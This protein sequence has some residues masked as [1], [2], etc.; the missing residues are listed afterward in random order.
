MKSKIIP[1]IIA[2]V[3]AMFFVIMLLA[4]LFAPELKYTTDNTVE[5]NATIVRVV[6]TKNQDKV[7]YVVYTDEYGDKLYIENATTLI[8]HAY[9]NTLGNGQKVSVL[10]PDSLFIYIDEVSCVPIVAME[11]EGHAVMTLDSSNIYEKKL[12]GRAIITGCVAELVSILIIIWC[13][14][15]IKSPGKRSVN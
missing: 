9:F 10:I 8:N 12:R 14:V 15:H 2:I 13:I 5:L 3:C 4:I 7:S 11:T 1:T 6:M